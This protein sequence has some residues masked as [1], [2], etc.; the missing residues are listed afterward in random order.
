[1]NNHLRA[2][3]DRGAISA[4]RR[5]CCSQY[6]TPVGVEEVRTKHDQRSTLSHFESSEVALE[7][8]ERESGTQFGP[9]CAEAF[10]EIPDE[11]FT[12]LQAQRPE[13]L[14]GL[15]ERV[16]T[17]RNIDPDFFKSEPLGTG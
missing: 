5:S 6:S 14:K 9:T 15:P 3:P 17:L 13:A 12:S 1:M 4:C 7:E 8:V 11:I 10:L 16:Q 2:T